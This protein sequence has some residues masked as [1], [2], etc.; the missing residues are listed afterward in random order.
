MAASSR[1]NSGAR[2]RIAGEQEVLS[3]RY[4]TGRLE[5]LRFEDDLQRLLR[6]ALHPPRQ[7][8]R[9]ARGQVSGIHCRCG[10]QV[11]DGAL[12][13]VAQQR[14]RAEEV[15]ALVARTQPLPAVM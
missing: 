2:G 1:S 9:D 5:P 8:Q 15:L 13:V 7:S 12:E 10:L 4:S 3:A 14:D 6:I 11:A